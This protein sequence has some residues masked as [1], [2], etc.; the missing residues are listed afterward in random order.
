M[1]IFLQFVK[2]FPWWYTEGAWA[3]AKFIGRQINFLS[4]SLA[5]RQLLKNI[6][7]PLY[8]FRGRWDRGIA[9]VV[10]LV[11][12]LLVAF[13]LAIGTGMFVGFLLAYLYFPVLIVYN[14]VGWWLFLAVYPSML[15][16]YW[17]FR[18]RSKPLLSKQRI[19]NFSKNFL[20]Y[21]D[22]RVRRIFRHERFRLKECLLR[23]LGTEDAEKFF[24]SIELPNPNLNKFAF[25]HKTTT[26]FEAALNRALAENH[27]QIKTIDL[28][29]AL[30]T[31]RADKDPFW[32]DSKLKDDEIQSAFDFF[33]KRA[34]LQ[35]Y[36]RKWGIYSLFRNK[37][38]LDRGLT[39]PLTKEL[40]RFSKDV[41][42]TRSSREITPLVGREEIFDLVINTIKD[43][44]GAVLI[45][46]RPGEG[47]SRVVEYLSECITA[48]EVPATLQDSRLVELDT[49]RILSGDA[50]IKGGEGGK[51]LIILLDE[52]TKNKKLIL[53]IDG[54][55]GLMGGNQHDTTN[56]S[57]LAKYVVDK[58]IRLVATSTQEDY[59]SILSKHPTFVRQFNKIQLGFHPLT[60][61]EIL[62]ILEYHAINLEREYD[63]VISAR[64]LRTI[65]DISKKHR[66]DIANPAYSLIL[67][68]ESLIEHK[69]HKFL[70][71]ED[72]KQTLYIKT[73]INLT[74]LTDAESQRLQNLEHEIHQNLIGQDLAVQQVADAL[75]RARL[76]LHHYEGPI[77]KFLFVGPT[78]VG[79]TEL[80]KIVAR[81][82]FASEEKML[83]LDMSEFQN[84]ASIRR[85]IGSEEHGGLLT[86]P[87]RGKPH[88][89]ILLDE[90]EKAHPDVLNLLLQVLDDGRITDG[91]GRLV[92]FRNTIVI[93]TSNAGAEQIFAGLKSGIRFEEISKQLK[94]EILVR[95]FRPEFLNRFSNIIIFEPHAIEQVQE[96]AK[97]LLDKE[98]KIFEKKEISFAFTED[99]P[100]VL[101][102][103]SYTKEMGARPLKNLITERLE[104]QLANGLL[105]HAFARHDRLVF[106]GKELR[107]VG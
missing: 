66:G 63:T 90:L 3:F 89:L 104:S 13:V 5:F 10:R 45:I 44:G 9:L 67:L 82:Q 40:N 60:D 103:D 18:D 77:A 43:R 53:F 91:R 102:T 74:E 7:K 70:G 55:A 2:V 75:R 59:D 24:Y 72:L 88:Q 96:I 100:R 71:S 42:M 65:V 12:L 17:L 106:D 20:Q 34:K 81:L 85:L 37:H 30:Y 35:A 107:K 73:G 86:E 54:L 78:G 1:Q 28:L 68:K 50:S 39:S 79:K 8:G 47:K 36:Q 4:H 27:T 57:I 62:Q 105:S 61:A 26:I 84:I 80:A 6:F 23:L 64:A 31:L 22:A 11:H 25:H 51:N 98:R 32:E 15:I 94:G 41:T 52:A 56:L 69:G 76:D 87:I 49:G 97:L 58:K 48:E 101:A 19:R 92:D 29:Y 99:A 16:I 93:A 33:E 83:R 21:S 95:H 46:G 38:G 14:Q